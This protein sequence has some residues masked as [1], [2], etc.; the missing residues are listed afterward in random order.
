MIRFVVLL[1]AVWGC[2]AGGVSRVTLRKSALTRQNLG[3]L[4]S[5]AYLK[6]LVNGDVPLNNFLDAQ[7]SHQGSSNARTM[8]A[9]I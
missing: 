6:G 2:A 7:V 3:T 9:Q 1:L 4:S 5:R 8:I